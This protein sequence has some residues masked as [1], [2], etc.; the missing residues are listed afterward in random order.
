MNK[1]RYILLLIIVSII[2]SL[3]I[4]VDLRGGNDATYEI[5]GGAI[6][7]IIAPYIITSLIKYRFKFSMWNWNFEDKSFLKTYIIIWCIWVLLNAAG[8]TN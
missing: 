5:L 3:I 6:A 2:A 4:E 8:S 1:K 7:F